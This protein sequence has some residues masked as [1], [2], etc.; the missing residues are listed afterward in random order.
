ML[1]VIAI[2]CSHGGRKE[3]TLLRPGRVP[4]ARSLD[5]LGDCWT[6]LVVRDLLRGRSRYSDILASLEG[7]SP[8]LLSDRLKRL[9][10]HGVVERS[11]YSGHPPRAEYRLTEK[12]KALGPVIRAMF[13]WGTRY[14]PL[15]AATGVLEQD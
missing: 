6:L 12:G 3:T 13:D 15:R 7:I 5:L 2:K 9:E 8:N 4:V 14:E 10:R 1:I 11:F